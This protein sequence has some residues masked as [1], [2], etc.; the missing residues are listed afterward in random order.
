MANITQDIDMLMC[1]IDEVLQAKVTALEGMI[2]DQEIAKPKTNV[3]SDLQ[4]VLIK[5]ILTKNF[6]AA[7]PSSKGT[8]TEIDAIKQHLKILGE[9]VAQLTT[10]VA[11]S[12]P[13]A[14]YQKDQQETNASLQEA[15]KNLVETNQSWAAVASQPKQDAPETS[16]RSQKEIS[17]V[18]RSSLL[19]HQ[20]ENER[21]L[22]VV[23]FGLKEGENDLDKFKLLCRSEMHCSVEPIACHRIGL[24][25]KDKIRPLLVKCKN[26]ADRRKVLGNA[27]LLRQSDF[28]NVKKHIFIA[29]DMSKE[30]REK[31]KKI[32]EER[33]ARFQHGGDTDDT[34]SAPGK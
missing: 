33:R 32:R 10:T 22:N 29:P 5:S 24:K 34:P 13:S 2:K 17:E 4:S 26:E 20:K 23:I 9:Q 12:I 14:Q 3:R 25:S 28:D 21:K 8:T 31:Q 27:K 7:D 19:E 6:L 15:I 11:A 16:Q 18:F 30:E 1:K